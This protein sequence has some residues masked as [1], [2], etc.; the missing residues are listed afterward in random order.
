M[1]TWSGWLF[2][3]LFFWNFYLFRH[4]HFFPL[5]WYV[6]FPLWIHLFI[7][8]LIFYKPSFFL[9]INSLWLFL[10]WIVGLFLIRFWNLWLALRIL[11]WL[12]TLRFVGWRHSWICLFCKLSVCNKLAC[13]L[14]VGALLIG[15]ILICDRYILISNCDI[16]IGGSN[17]LICY[18]WLSICSWSI[19][20]I[21]IGMLSLAWLL[22]MRLFWSY[23]FLNF[24]FLLLFLHLWWTL[25]WN[26][27]LYIWFFLNF[28]TFFTIVRF[29]MPTSLWS[30][31]WSLR[32]R[33]F[34]LF[35]TSSFMMLV[36]ID[37]LK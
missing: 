15:D 23:T 31:N 34:R 8:F 18:R 9:Q 37:M 25:H 14:L 5:Y 20:H 29:R 13:H 33:V 36:F 12:L 24:R 19:S 28:L 35:V 22:Q 10:C 2:I 4:L 3:F 32:F 16:L 27:F 17:I 30:F 26:G 7:C 21:S 6:Y 11:W 1:F